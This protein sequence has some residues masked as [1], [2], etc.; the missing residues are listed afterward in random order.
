MKER[1]KNIS[2]EIMIQKLE[3][4]QANF[5]QRLQTYLDQYGEHFEY[6]L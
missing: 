1:I 5:P 4:I 3:E 6:L 2:R